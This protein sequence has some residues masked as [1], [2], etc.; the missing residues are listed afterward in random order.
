MGREPSVRRMSASHY[1]QFFELMARRSALIDL[2]E[3]KQID[4]TEI[5]PPIDWCALFGN[6]NPVEIEIGCGKGRFLLEAS[7]RNP[8]V[9]YV[10]VERAL[11]Y[12]EHAKEQLR[13]GSA[14]EVF[15]IWSDA[16]YLVDRYIGE[17][18][19]DAYHVYFPDP[20]PKKRHRKRRLFRNEVWLRGLIR[21]LDPSGGRIYVATDYA[22]YFYEIHDCLTHI[23][24]LV[25]LPTDSAEIGH[26]PTSFEMKYRAEGRKIYR[27][28]YQMDSA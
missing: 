12:V 22:E 27:A 16:A 18:T 3:D 26:I 5:A 4:L 20:W 1:E 24:P 23:P 15:L 14:T 13:K 21:T 28:V 19:V 7:R 2:R 10:G 8:D 9:N 11:K 17:N 6:E 25:Y